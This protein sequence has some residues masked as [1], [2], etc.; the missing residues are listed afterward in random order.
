MNIIKRLF[1]SEHRSYKL[2]VGK[3]VR[4][5]SSEL[6][7][8]LNWNNGDSSSTGL[9]TFLMANQLGSDA[10]NAITKDKI[11]VF[12]REL[13]KILMSYEKDTWNRNTSVDYDPCRALCQA[14]E[15]AKISF[16]AFPCKSS[17]W[18]DKDNKVRASNGYQR[19]WLEL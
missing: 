15:S 6:Q 9:M 11:L 13:T 17:C 2:A 18:I 7:K 19:A 3:V 4:F 12:E 5:W 8:K 10:K 1:S 14:A 16:H